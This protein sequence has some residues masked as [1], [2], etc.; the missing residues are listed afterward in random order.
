MHR[1]HHAQVWNRGGATPPGVEELTRLARLV[2]PEAVVW[3]GDT[4]LLVAEQ[5]VVILGVDLPILCVNSW[6]TSQQSRISQR[7]LLFEETQACWLL[8]L[9]CVATRTN[10]W[11][12]VVCPEHIES[13]VARHNDHM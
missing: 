10:F 1:T 4:H 6:R 8:L 5:G 9:M 7:I 2:K 13:F 11:F 3:R 12:R